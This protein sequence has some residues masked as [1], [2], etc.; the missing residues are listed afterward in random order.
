LAWDEKRALTS[1]LLLA[2]VATRILP[3]GGHRWKK[4]EF[5]PLHSARLAVCFLI[6]SYLFYVKCDMG[7][8]FTYQH[9]QSKKIADDPKQT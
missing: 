7:T 3:E 6:R 9:S 4:G 1:F 8:V 5:L 2:A